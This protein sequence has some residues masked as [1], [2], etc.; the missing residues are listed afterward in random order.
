MSVKS[1]TT[2]LDELDFEIISLLQKD[3]TITHSV[4]AQKLKRSQPAIGAR[5]KKL[6]DMGLISTQIGVDF[7]KFQDYYLVRA[8][9]QTTKSDELMEL[10]QC[11]PYVVNC[12][13]MSGDY[14][15]SVLLAG[16]N[17]KIIDKV[18]DRHYRNQSYVRKVTM[19]RVVE[20]AKQ[21]VLPIELRADT[22]FCGE[23]DPCEFEPICRKNREMAQKRSPEQIISALETPIPT[24]TTPIP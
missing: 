17:I 13:K 2:S 5:V 1:L 10:A 9:I 14:N 6:F 15:I 24:T 20:L 8:D 22:H 4:I 18:L 16:A 7:K 11:C 23:K 19:E 12:M 3:P 21:F